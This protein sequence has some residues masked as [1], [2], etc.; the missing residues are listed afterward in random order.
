MRTIGLEWCRFDVSNVHC[1]VYADFSDAMFMEVSVNE[2]IQACKLR[3]TEHIVVH[4]HHDFNEAL[5]NLCDGLFS[6]VLDLL[7]S[8]RD[9]HFS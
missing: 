2:L 6:R 4:S 3:L 9:F 7:K 8:G 5:I 1:F